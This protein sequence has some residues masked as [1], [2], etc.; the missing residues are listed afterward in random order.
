MA[1]HW[2]AAGQE[3]PRSAVS[4][5]DPL[6]VIAPVVGTMSSSLPLLSTMTH[7]PLLGHATWHLYRKAVVPDLAPR[8]EF[9][10][11]MTTPRY[12]ADFPAVLWPWFKED[13]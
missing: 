6:L 13:R 10:V 5:I 11:R 3:T 9:R 4:S 7:W 12:A 2:V 1:V 8:A